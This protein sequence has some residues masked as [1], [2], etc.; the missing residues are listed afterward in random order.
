[1]FKLNSQTND[2]LQFKAWSHEIRGNFPKIPRI[3]CVDP[4]ITQKT[5]SLNNIPGEFVEKPGVYD[6]ALLCLPRHTVILTTTEAKTK[7]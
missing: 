1:M 7:G 3:V 4:R 6:K 2:R 5:L